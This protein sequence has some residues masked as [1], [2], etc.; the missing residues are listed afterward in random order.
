V[1][2]RAKTESFMQMQGKIIKGVGGFYEV[3]SGG[4]IYTCRAR[5]KFRR[6]GLTPLPG[7]H[8][9]FTPGAD[10]ILGSVDKILPRS[11]ALRRPAVANVDLL[12]LVATAV[13]PEPDLP[14]LDKLLLASSLLRM[15]TLL[16]VNKCDLATTEAVEAITRQ[17]EH[18]VSKVIPVSAKSGMGIEELLE[19]MKG[20]CSCFSGQSGVGKTSVLNRLFPGREMETGGMSQKTSRGRHT[21]RHAELL[22]LPGGGEVADTPGFSLMEMDSLEPSQ[23]P[24]CY[25]E[26]EPYAGQC[27]F[28]GCLHD[29][30]PGCS[31]KAAVEAGAIPQE[32]HRR[33]REILA[34]TREKWRNRYD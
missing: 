4:T 20:K 28:A 23:L 17:Y 29:S 13:E 18:A 14:L 26:F 25:P 6:E 31:V 8:V 9:E 24:F 16:A 12:V 2:A 27:R 19:R 1:P 32:R 3:L 34:E 5:G 11:N 30:E 33:Y 21:T 22:T 15:E 7:D 10:E